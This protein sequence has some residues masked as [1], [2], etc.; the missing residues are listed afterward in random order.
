MQ[1]ICFILLPFSP[2]P[3]HEIDVIGTLIWQ[4]GNFYRHTNSVR[5]NHTQV[6]RIKI[7][8]NDRSFINGCFVIRWL[9]Q[10]FL[11]LIK[12]SSFFKGSREYHGFIGWHFGSR[13][14]AIWS[15]QK[16][17]SAGQTFERW[18]LHGCDNRSLSIWGYLFPLPNPILFYFVGLLGHEIIIW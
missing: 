10:D 1:L 16:I 13:S 4:V 9:K 12:Q 2:I 3:N 15:F 17:R 18:H 7:D 11:T 5:M 6:N 8:T 14:E